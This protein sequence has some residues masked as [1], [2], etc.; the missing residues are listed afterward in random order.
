MTL[1]YLEYGDRNWDWLRVTFNRAAQR[2]QLVELALNVPGEGTQIKEINQQDEYLVSLLDFIGSHSNGKIL[3]RFGAE[4]DIWGDP[5]TPE[6]FIT[7]FR[8]VATLARAVY[9]RQGY[10]SCTKYTPYHGAACGNYPTYLPPWG[11]P[12]CTA[13]SRRILLYH[14]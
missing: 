10:S 5:A 2:G 3:L 8:H 11:K 14:V 12:S 1:V 4:M 13:R 7:A 6:D 9:K